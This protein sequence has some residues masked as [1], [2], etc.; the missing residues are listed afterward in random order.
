[1]GVESEADLD[2]I[3]PNRRNFDSSQLFT[4][5][6][7]FKGPPAPTP[8]PTP[9]P[10]FFEAEEATAFGTGVLPKTAT[11]ANTGSGFVDMAGTG[12]WFEWSGADLV[13]EE[14][15][16]CT[17]NVRYTLGGSKHDRD[18]QVT[19]NG[20]DVGILVFAGTGGWDNWEY[21]SLTA[22][23]LEGPNTLRITAVG[24]D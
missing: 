1:M 4:E 21:S 12:S 19:L 18:C 5:Q 11:G 10:G 16:L 14:G 13:L 6:D 15:G 23:C 17:I 3:L 20:L 2:F 9:P 24:T 8:A 7:L 22:N